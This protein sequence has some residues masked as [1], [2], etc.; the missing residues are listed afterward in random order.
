MWIDRSRGSSTGDP[1][2]SGRSNRGFA[3]S[4]ETCPEAA[5]AGPKSLGSRDITRGSGEP[6]SAI[7]QD[8]ELAADTDEKH[9]L[10]Q[11]FCD[12]LI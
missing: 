12:R 5:A 7:S 1:D 3:K 4:T 6:N 9:D 8:H 10:A 2:F 11:Q